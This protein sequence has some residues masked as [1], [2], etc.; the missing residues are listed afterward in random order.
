[1]LIQFIYLKLYLAGV[2]LS[3]KY[4]SHKTKMC[5]S[6]LKGSLTYTTGFK[7]ISDHFVLA[8]SVEDPS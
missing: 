6:P 5:G 3:G 4:V 1:M 8:C 7:Y 2:F